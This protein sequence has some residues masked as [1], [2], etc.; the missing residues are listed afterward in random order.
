MAESK[1][2]AASSSLAL[3]WELAS[4]NGAV[5]L[6][7]AK[8]LV[9]TLQHF[10]TTHSSPSLISEESV[11]AKDDDEQSSPVA[12]SN[13]STG[14]MIATQD[15]LAAECAPDLCYGLKRLL[16]GL[17]SARQGARQGFSVALTEVLYIFEKIH[18]ISNNHSMA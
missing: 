9:E 2:A 14:K 3:Y 18:C 4:T 11:I 6:K 16:R 15:D 12:V 5:R 7:A 17:P 13:N 8:T 10:Q 1:A